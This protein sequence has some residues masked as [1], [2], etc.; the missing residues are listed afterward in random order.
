MQGRSGADLGLPDLTLAETKA[1]GVRTMGVGVANR[2]GVIA[3]HWKKLLVAALAR[4]ANPA[5]AAVGCAINTQHMD[6]AAAR[7]HLR[8]VEDRMGLP[9]TDPFRYGAGVQVDA[10]VRN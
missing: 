1:N 5:C 2:G 3:Q 9:A 6:D 4:V 7:G 10:L 8:A